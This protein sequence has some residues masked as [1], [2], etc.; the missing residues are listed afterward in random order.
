MTQD[1][2]KW[3]KA[4]AAKRYSAPKTFSPPPDQSKPESVA[5]RHGA[6]YDND[7]S[8]WVRGPKGESKPGFD[9]TRNK[10]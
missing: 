3:G 5:D 8:G 7:A 6:Q 9:H 2:Q 1:T 10:R 4:A